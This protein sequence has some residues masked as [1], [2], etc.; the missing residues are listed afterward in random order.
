MK[1]C[2]YIATI[3]TAVFCIPVNAISIGNFEIDGAIS[4]H[5]MISDLNEASFLDVRVEIDG[6]PINYVLEQVSDDQVLINI[7][8]VLLDQQESLIEIS[9]NS[10]A[11]A[12]T[13]SFAYRN[14]AAMTSL[15]NTTQAAGALE[16]ARKTPKNKIIVP[17]N[18]EISDDSSPGEFKDGILTI[19]ITKGQTSVG[20]AVAHLARSENLNVLILPGDRDVHDALLVG[21]VSEFTDLYAAS[22]KLVQHVYIDR[23][24]Q[25]IRIVG[26]NSINSIQ[27]SL[28]DSNIANRTNIGQLLNDIA[29][30]NGYTALVYPGDAQTIL[31]R[32]VSWKGVKGIED[33]GELVGE[34][35]GRLDID[36]TNKLMRARKL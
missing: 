30:V 2:K 35:G 18:T 14:D 9:V 11:S 1:G 7:S 33:L 10:D 3:L 29:M 36:R 27:S 6:I 32:S 24:N 31:N 25:W 13:R 12:H 22:D 5:I 17:A 21:S 34:N 4:G 26:A 15:S 19:N 28:F 8:D 16:A 20:T 23:V